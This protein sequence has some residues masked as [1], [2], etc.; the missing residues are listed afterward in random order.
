[1]TIEKIPF[2]QEVWETLSNIDVGQY[3]EKAGKFN[4]LSWTWA[5]SQLMKHYPESVYRFRKDKIYA[6]GT[7]EVR[8]EIAVIRGNE[9]AVRYMWLP[10]MNHQH[11]AIPNPDAFQ[12]NTAR[13]RCL[14]KCIAMHG[15]GLYIFSGQDLPESVQEKMQELI[16]QEQINNLIDL[17]DAQELA[18]EQVFKIENIESW[19]QITQGHYTV[20]RD[21]LATRMEKYVARQAEKEKALKANA[22]T[23]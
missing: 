21:K 20:I 8:C 16:T 13:M 4:Y 12:I 6:D 10:V 22:E 23:H 7:V 18:H 1:M 5:W 15:L 3:I 9:H 17:A 19:E 14:V 2:E 11:K